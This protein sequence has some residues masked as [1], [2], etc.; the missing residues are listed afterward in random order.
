M[1]TRSSSRPKHLLCLSVE[2]YKSTFNL[3]KAVCN[4]GFFMMA[5]NKWNPSTK[6]LQRPLRLMDQRCSVMVTISHPPGENNL[7]V[8]VHDVEV[9]SL[10]DQQAILALS[11]MLR[12]SDEDENAVIEFQKLYPEA[13][14]EGFGRIFRSP[15]IFEDA[16]KSLLLCYCSW[17]RTLKMAKSLCELQLQLSRSNRKKQQLVENF[18]I[19][20]ELLE[21]SESNLQKQCGLGMRAGYIMKLA[22]KVEKNS[23]MEK[24]EKE[25]SRFV[26]T[27]LIEFN[28]F[29][30]FSVATTLMCMGKYEKV[31]ADSETK[32]HLKE[33]YG[34][35]SSENQ[36]L[37][38]IVEEIY[39][40]YTPF[41]C[42]A[43]W[44]EVV[45]NY[46]KSHGRLS[47][48]EESKYHTITGDYSNKRKRPSKW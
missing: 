39:G 28:G 16:V 20:K 5:P 7:H 33:V 8:H 13:K 36:P 6:S 31:P 23:I 43:Y 41:Q 46:E 25:R 29:G 34:I 30:P 27:R 2:K 22:K 14:E 12:I 45:Q 24:L 37:H 42:I 48:L 1:K 19:P 21:I 18:P 44:F 9:L 32:R 38:K 17:Q 4:H 47:E 15:S 10:E 35:D 26:H 11:R 3:E 40:K